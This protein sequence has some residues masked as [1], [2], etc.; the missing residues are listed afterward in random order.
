[1]ASPDTLIHLFDHTFDNVLAPKPPTE[2]VAPDG[3][4]PG[5]CHC[6]PLRP[7]FATLEQAL[8][9]ALIWAQATD[10]AQGAEQRVA[11]RQILLLEGVCQCECGSETPAA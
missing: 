10:P 9:E 11:H 2:K 5:R 4:L 3:E 8:L 6:N 1:M 7:H